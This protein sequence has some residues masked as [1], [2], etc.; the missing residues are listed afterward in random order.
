MKL[1]TIRLELARNHDF[2]NGSRD[3]GYEFSAPLTPDGHIDAEAFGKLRSACK[4]RRFWP[5]EDDK[6]GSLHHTRDHKWVFSY[7]PGEADD[8]AFY[9]LD[10]HVFR[11][12]EYVTI[13]EPDGVD[14]TFRVAITN[15]A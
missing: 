13:R 6:T 3:R 4:V 2:P 12:G 7:A 14:H 8:E 10:R 5:G 11:P 15:A 9:R 1:S